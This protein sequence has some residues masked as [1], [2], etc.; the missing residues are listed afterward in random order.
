MM[1]AWLSDGEIKS[2]ISVDADGL[3]AIRSSKIEMVV[4]LESGTSV[5][6]S[7]SS[8]CFPVNGAARVDVNK[9][10]IKPNLMAFD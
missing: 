1:D 2:G 3:T 5:A 10:K 4:K 6:S 8:S 7:V 9:E